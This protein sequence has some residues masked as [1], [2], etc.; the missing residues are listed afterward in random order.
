MLKITNLTK[1]YGSGDPV[2]KQLN[3]TVEGEQLTSVIGSSGAGKSTLLRCINRLVE[4]T[5]GSVELNGTE[6]TTLSRR[7][8]RTARRRI[9]M[10]FQ[11]FN[12]IDRLTVMENVQAGRLG[13]ISTWAGADPPLPKG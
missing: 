6:F 3:L 2:L 5:S 1:R 12:L 9:G 4:P 11:G 10:V 13:Y 7:E 8:L